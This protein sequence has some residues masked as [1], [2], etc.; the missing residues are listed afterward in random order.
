MP[1]YTIDISVSDM[2]YGKSHSGNHFTCYERQF[3]S[4]LFSMMPL[5]VFIWHGPNIY[6]YAI[7]AVQSLKGK[8]RLN[9]SSFTSIYKMTKENIG[10]DCL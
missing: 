8:G 2:L 9:T 6:N 10:A 3:I 4:N 7:I 5:I 1:L